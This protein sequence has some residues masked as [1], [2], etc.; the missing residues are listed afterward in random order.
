MRVYRTNRNHHPGCLA[1]RAESKSGHWSQILLPTPTGP[2]PRESRPLPLTSRKRSAQY[3]PHLPTI[4]T[5]AA[6]DGSTPPLS[7]QHHAGL[8]ALSVPLCLLSLHT[9]TPA[10]QATER[11]SVLVGFYPLVS[12]R[13]LS[14]LSTGQ[15]LLAAMLPISTSPIRGN[16]AES[17]ESGRN[18]QTLPTIPTDAA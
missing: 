17:A 12:C 7:L 4:W 13:F 14:F 9:L 2:P 11:S 6:L 10:L 1:L 15:P 16:G 3:A 5:A 8:T 18:R